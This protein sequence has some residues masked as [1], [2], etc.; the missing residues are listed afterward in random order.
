[1][2]E[3]EAGEVGKRAKV[4]SLADLDK[5][6]ENPPL[7]D[8]PPEGVQPGDS[9]WNDYVDYWN[10]RTRL[11]KEPDLTPYNQPAALATDAGGA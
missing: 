1:M 9:L 8:S 7:K 3:A 4:E 2:A 5:L 11:Q 6:K 10:E